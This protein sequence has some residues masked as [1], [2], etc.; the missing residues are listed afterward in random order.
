MAYGHFN[1]QSYAGRWLY[2]LYIEDDHRSGSFHSKAMNK[3]K[4]GPTLTSA[5]LQNQNI[6]TTCFRDTYPDVNET[7]YNN[8]N[9]D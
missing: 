6:E 1:F 3:P 4:F 9:R 7:I 2:I 8:V 5:K